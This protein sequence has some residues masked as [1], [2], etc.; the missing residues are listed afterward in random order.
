[1]TGYY[2]YIKWFSP[3]LIGQFS[4]RFQPPSEKYHSPYPDPGFPNESG[5]GRPQGILTSDC[6]REGCIVIKGE[7]IN[8][9][10]SKILI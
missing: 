1:M 6:V 9:T 4:Y 10:L 5:T 3:L 7:G 8:S 2:L